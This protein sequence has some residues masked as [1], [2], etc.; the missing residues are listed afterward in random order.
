MGPISGY[1]LDTFANTSDDIDLYRA[2]RNIKYG[3]AYN[4]YYLYNMLEMYNL[5]SRTFFTHVGELGFVLHTM[6]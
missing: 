5:E 1:M 4:R 3:I 6:V 2:I